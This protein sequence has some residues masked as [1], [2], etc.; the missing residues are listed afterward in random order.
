MVAVGRPGNYP[1]APELLVLADSGGSNSPRT[2]AFKYALQTRLVDP[3]RIRVTVSHY[4]SGS[5]KWNP[6]CTGSSTTTKTGLTVTA[7]P[8]NKNIRG[9]SRSP[10]I[11]SPPSPSNLTRFNPSSTTPSFR[12]PEE[13]AKSGKL[14]LRGPLV[15]ATSA[16]HDLVGSRRARSASHG[17]VVTTRNL[18]AI[19]TSPSATVGARAV[20][21]PLAP[22]W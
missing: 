14:F 15:R 6:S 5:S 11:D 7:H 12:E 1:G 3:H 13:Q 20:T 19:A 10:S 22:T 21:S 9:A 18:P 4:P 8:L 17:T 16:R 2:R